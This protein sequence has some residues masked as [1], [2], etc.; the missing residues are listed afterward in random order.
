MSNSV[1]HSV[2]QHWWE[3]KEWHL[4]AHLFS[5]PRERERERESRSSLNSLPVSLATSRTGLETWGGRGRPDS[6][7]G[8]WPARLHG[9]LER[10]LEQD[11][12]VYIHTTHKGA[13]VWCEAHL[14]SLL[15]RLHERAQMVRQLSQGVSVSSNCCTLLLLCWMQSKIKLKIAPNSTGNVCVQYLLYEHLHSPPGVHSDP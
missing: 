15:Q 7:W 4:L 10:V 2:Q 5:P 1:C 8:V 11:Y 12:F 6:H 3:Q 13:K 14:W 9:L